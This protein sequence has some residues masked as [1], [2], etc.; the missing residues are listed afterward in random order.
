MGKNLVI[1]ESPAK[2]RTLSRILG[3]NY[4]IKASLGHVRDLPKSALGVDVNNNFAPRYVNIAQRRK[5]INEVK[6]AAENISAIYLATDPDREG[7]AISWH[8]IEAAKLGEGKVPIRRV[9]FHEITK[10]A[11][12]QAFQHPRSI[13]MHLVDAQQAR[14]VLD[15]LVGYKLSPLLWKKVQKGLSAGRVQSAAVRIVVDREREIE[16]FIPIEFWII[17]VELDK[18]V[19]KTSKSSFKAQFVGLADGKQINIPSQEKAYQLKDDLSKAEYAVKSIAVKEMLR[20]PSPPFITST[21][22]QEAWRRYHFTAKHTM[23]IAQQLYE[24]INIGDEGPT[25]LITYMR[26]DSTHVAATAITETRDFIKSKYGEDYL[27]AQPRAFSKKGKWAQEA[28]EAIRPTRIYREPD[29]IRSY[30]KPEQMKLYELIWKRMVAS[31]MKAALSDITTV[32]IEA[33]C[34]ESS[35][36]YSLKTVNSISKFPGFTI[37]YSESK[38]DETEDEKDCSAT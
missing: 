18:K 9:A 7:E 37:L 21:M 13:D 1:V 17:E 11:V 20:Q 2:S 14:R 24:G 23:A 33:K 25:G 19:A 31:Q 10:E 30:L 29:Q 35:K 38:D 12:E 6:E 16:K 36:E 27:P 5:T 22:Q 26:T 15:R 4:I 8:L 3:D 28:H 32:D 34:I